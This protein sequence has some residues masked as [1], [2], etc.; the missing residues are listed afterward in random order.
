MQ[1]VPES[2]SAWKAVPHRVPQPIWGRSIRAR[3][4]RKTMDAEMNVKCTGWLRICIHPAGIPPSKV[5]PVGV[6]VG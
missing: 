5:A 3:E 1:T 2:R 6:P 4:V